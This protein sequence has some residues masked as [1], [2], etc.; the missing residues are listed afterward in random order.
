MYRNGNSFSTFDPEVVTE[1]AKPK[2]SGKKLNYYIKDEKKAIRDY[3]KSGLP[4]LASD[5]AKHLKYLQKLKAE[6]EKR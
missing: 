3:K 4:N 2:L 5:E 1:M 6:K